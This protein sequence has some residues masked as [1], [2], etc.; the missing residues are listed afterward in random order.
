MKVSRTV[1][2]SLVFVLLGLVGW[3]TGFYT[4]W[5]WFDS[6]GYLSVLQKILFTQWALFLA[7]AGLFLLALFGNLALA[8]S[9]AQRYQPPFRVRGRDIWVDALREAQVPERALGVFLVLIA[10][11][12]ALIMGLTAAG[13]WEMTLRFLQQ[14]PFGTSDPLFGLDVGFYVFAIPFY[15]FL[16]SWLMGAVIVVAISVAAFYLYRLYGPTLLRTGRL[17]FAPAR[18]VRAHLAGLGA[19]ILLLFAA[20]YRLETYEL[21]YSPTGVVFGA[22]YTNVHA[23]MPALTVLTLIAA[24]AAVLVVA[25][26]FSDRLW[27]PLAGVGIWVAAI[28]VGTLIY[29]YFVQKFVVEPSEITYERPYIERNIAATRAAYGLDN[30]TEESYPADLTPA[31]A[32][33]TGNPDT[34]DNIR[35][36][37][38]R[39]LLDTY[40]QIQ[41]I[42]GYYD[43]H[44]VDIDRYTIDGR[45]RQVMLSARELSADKLPAEAK[46]WQSLHLQYTHGYGLA[47]SAVNDISQEGLP[48]LF[49]KDVPPVGA[50]PVARPEI[51]YGE[52]TN[53][54][55]I[56]DT[57]LQ[58]FDYPKGDQNV[59]SGYQGAGGIRLDS[60]LRKLVYAWHF[61]DA[62]I[63]LSNYLT[64]N[65]RI[66]YNRTVQ[67]RVHTLA[68]F[69]MLDHDPYLVLD[70]GRLFWIQDAYTTTDKYPY[71]EPYE[72]RLN[73]IRNSIKAVVDAYD[74]SVTFY[75]ADATDP[76]LRTYAAIFPELFRPLDAM[77]AGLRAHLRYPEDLFLVQVGMYR[78]YHMQD[79][80]TFYLREDL[81]NVPREVYANKEQDLE[82]YYVIMRLPSE[83]QEEF[84]LMLP[85]TPPNKQNV[86]S[87]LAA[88]S[89]GQNYGRLLVYKFPKDK[90]VYGPLQVEGRITQ[91]PT[92][93]AQ[94]ALWN[95]AGSQ[96]IR[97]NL[98]IIPIGTS[99]L[100]VEPVYLQAAN[101][102]LPELKRV[103]VAAGDR[104]VMEPSLGA[105]LARLFDLQTAAPAATSAPPASPATPPAAG[106]PALDAASLARQANDLYDKAQQQIAKGDWAG[107]G[108]SMRQLKDVLTRLQQATGGG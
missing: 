42:R 44:D 13:Q 62:N 83:K 25:Y 41:S 91:D 86:I 61:G 8:R 54:Y 93:S 47:M 55:V 15:R 27:L 34:I 50:L 81:W 26:A 17:P 76:V 56:V 21:V 51:Y 48:S 45:Y 101:G 35:I 11:F 19:F 23:D 108:E 36:W 100:Y 29:P 49:I 7:G 39:P 14:Q 97:G 78:T 94:F 53:D 18:P 24:L 1:L 12:I 79:P 82:P 77:P 106:T 57:R 68:P 89:D 80:Q 103:V 5:L 95:Q 52:E 38:H 96:V 4:D 37:D 73:Y 104:I 32:D 2:V 10:L 98:L 105:G 43:F 84:L 88:R 9:V 20:S 16:L 92:I 67:S 60:Y 64:D 31:Q 70:D 63:I 72:G 90:L 40:N 65:S 3:G 22:S 87:W 33:V 74:G 6:L 75:I 102:R 58:E 107:Y 28:L 99:N 59:F 69:L 85:M 71:S 30:V 46:T 66:L